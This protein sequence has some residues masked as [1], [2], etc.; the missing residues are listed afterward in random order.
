[1]PR[2]RAVEAVRQGCGRV[3]VGEWVAVGV[4][5]AA[6]C[7]GKLFLLGSSAYRTEIG[8]AKPGP[9]MSSSVTG[10]EEFGRSHPAR[11]ALNLSQPS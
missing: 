2:G 6:D 7:F 8:R 11:T 4:E 5:P 1:M 9:D 10:G 3:I